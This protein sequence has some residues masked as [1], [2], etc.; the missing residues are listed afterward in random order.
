ML[1]SATSPLFM[2]WRISRNQ[3]DWDQR[4]A[5]AEVLGANVI[6]NQQF[7]VAFPTHHPLHPNYP[8]DRATAEGEALICDGDVILNLD[9]LN[10]GGTLQAAGTSVQKS[11]ASPWMISIPTD[12]HSTIMSCPR[13][14]CQFWRRPTVLSHWPCRSWTQARSELTRSRLVRRRPGWVP[15]TSYLSVLP[16]TRRSGIV[17]RHMCVF[18]SVGRYRRSESMACSTILAVMVA[19]VSAPVPAWWWVRPW[20]SR[21]R[22]PEAI[23]GRR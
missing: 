18:P 12:G 8:N 13:L 21:G 7:A 2:V 17:P 14:I 9:W 4:I 20:R 3:V 6:T 23:I 1:K 10:F 16:W 5:F 19:R 11:L 15:S 22:L